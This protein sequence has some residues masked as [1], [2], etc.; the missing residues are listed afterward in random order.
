MF[1]TMSVVLLTILLVG[2]GNTVEIPPAHVGKLS[3]SSGF[4]KGLIPPSK[5]RLDRFCF[6]CDSL[7]LVEA[8]D[9]PIKEDMKIFMPKDELNIA[10]EVRGTFSIASDEKNV[11]QIFDR[12]GAVGEGDV[13]KIGIEKVYKTYGE[14]IIREAVRS[15]ITT[16]SIETLMNNRDA[17]GKELERVVRE[18]LKA[19]P[20]TIRYFGL[21]DIQPPPVIVEAQE[22]RKRR[23]VAIGQAEAD[24][25]VKL[26]EAE[27]ALEVAMKQQEVD[28]KEAE[29]QVLVDKKLAEGVSQAFVAQR[30]LKVLET[31]AASP[32]KVFFMPM[33]AM[34]NPGM[35]V[36]TVN[37]ALEKK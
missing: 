19:T 5:I 27:A 29:T 22:A 30:A 1:K 33:E 26:K 23:E 15:L 3:T 14:P 20:G 17:I 32:N 16:Y 21:A 7:I 4:Q 25:L 31:M 13:K 12:I 34:S 9:F 10:L 37:K 6:V 35:M 18:K 8:S 28:L 11:T 24:K 2:C 36:G